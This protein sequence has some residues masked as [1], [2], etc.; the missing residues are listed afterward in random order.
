MTITATNDDVTYSSE[1]NGVHSKHKPYLFI[2]IFEFCAMIHDSMC[3]LNIKHIND[4]C[5]T[6]DPLNPVLNFILELRN[7]WVC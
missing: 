5:H 6:I 3:H 7:D 4:C 1:L 2:C